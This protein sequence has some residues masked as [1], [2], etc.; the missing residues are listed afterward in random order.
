MGDLYVTYHLI[1]CRWL[2]SVSAAELISLYSAEDPVIELVNTNLT[3]NIYDPEKIWFVEF[4]AHWCG[5]CQRFSPIWKQLA[6]D[7]D[8][9]FPL[10]F[11]KKKV[12]R[13]PL[14]LFLLSNGKADADDFL[15][16]AAL[17][18]SDLWPNE[19]ISIWP[20]L[21]SRVSNDRAFI[22]MSYSIQMLSIQVDIEILLFP[23]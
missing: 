14:K 6:R 23:C 17:S 15:S 16:L 2:S 10:T 12:E 1:F 19:F 3:V 21:T 4:Y 22:K 7:F 18:A 11:E 8:G 13:R 5:Y 9:N 20:L